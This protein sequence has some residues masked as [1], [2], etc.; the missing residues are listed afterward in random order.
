MDIKNQAMYAVSQTLN[1]EQP[2]GCRFSC[3]GLH[4]R[5]NSKK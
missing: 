3:L 1:V 4:I 2:P 5:T